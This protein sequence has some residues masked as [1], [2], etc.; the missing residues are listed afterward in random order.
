M[1]EYVE[2][3]MLFGGG[4]EVTNSRKIQRGAL[5]ACFLFFFCRL[6]ARAVSLIHS[7]VAADVLYRD[8]LLPGLLL[9]IR[10][11]MTWLSVLTVVLACSLLAKRIPEKAM[12]GMVWGFTLICFADGAAMFLS[13]LLSGAF[14][15]SF[16]ALMGLAL[17]VGTFL[18]ECAFVWLVYCIAVRSATSEKSVL[19]A[20]GLHMLGY[21]AMEIAYLIQFLI[22]V[23]FSPYK[24]EVLS[25]LRSFGG[26]VLWQGLALWLVAVL[27]C[28]LICR[29]NRRVIM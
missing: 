24:N 25:I 9:G 2:I 8:G 18:A 1:I 27:I 20:C 17:V 16:F 13:D 5:L 19:W 21:L 4:V 6:A 22:E 29:R 3:R 23:D 7:A 14:Q 28:R 11:V 12:S 15:D 26:I 10:A